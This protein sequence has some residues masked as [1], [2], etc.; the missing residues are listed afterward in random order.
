MSDVE[1]WIVIVGLALVTVVTRDFFL[2]PGDAIRLPRRVEHA[3][4]YAPACALTALVAPEMFTQHGALVLTL[5]NPKLIG[6]LVAGLTMVATG[7]SLLTMAV[8]MVAF[9][10]ARAWV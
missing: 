5:A 10:I 2:I 3:L 6:G 7:R 4:R 1:I 9:W 8:G